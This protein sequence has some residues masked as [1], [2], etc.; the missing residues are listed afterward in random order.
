M[1][2][3]FRPSTPDDGPAIIALLRGAGLNPN[4]A[5]SDLKW[6]YW[7]ERADWRGPRSFVLTKDSEIVAHAGI[8]PGTCLWNGKRLTVVH[9]VDWAASR[10]LVGAGVTLLRHISGLADA[11]IGVDGSQATL[12][13]RPMLG[14]RSCGTATMYVRAIHPLRRL[15]SEPHPSWR[16]LPRFARGVLWRVT[17]PSHQ[18]GAWHACKLAPA[19][20]QSVGTVLPKA[21]ANIAV[22]ERSTALFEHVL[23]CP[24]ASMDLYSIKKAGNVRGYFLLAFVPGQARLVDCWMDSDEPGAWLAMMQ[25]AAH[26]AKQAPAIAELVTVA[27]DPMLSSYLLQSGFHA[28]WMTPVDVLAGPGFG[29]PP[30]CLR[31][32]MLDSDAAFRHPG[33][34]EFWA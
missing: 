19:Q 28:R 18:D 9:G 13:L 4:S 21:D 8:V 26:A 1:N 3:W 29:P 22:L 10:A 11:V 27:S 20:V 14:F 34:A 32:Q 5:P 17:A 12:R 2:I 25:C 33:H 24:I 23:K 6:K 30:K 15:A 16:T 31:F 7:H